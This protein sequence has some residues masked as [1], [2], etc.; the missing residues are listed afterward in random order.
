[1]KIDFHILDLIKVLSMRNFT[2]KKNVQN[3][4]F[5]K[6]K[7]KVQIK[8]FFVFSWKNRYVNVS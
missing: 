2:C 6:V 1:M 4:I 5:S 7:K 8:H 3:M